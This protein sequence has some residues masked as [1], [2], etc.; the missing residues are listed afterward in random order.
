[1]TDLKIM[2][3]K[4]HSYEVTEGLVDRDISNTISIETDKGYGKWFIRIT[5]MTGDDEPACVCLSAAEANGIAEFIA[6]HVRKR[7]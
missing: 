3:T 2:E 1:M 6:S 5:E 7:W 4:P